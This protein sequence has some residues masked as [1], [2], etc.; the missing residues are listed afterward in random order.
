[1]RDDWLESLRKESNEES[2]H[3][4]WQE[5]RQYLHFLASRSLDRSLASK[6]DASDIAQHSLLEM[7]NDFH[8]FKG[9]TKEELKAWLERLV[10]HNVRDSSRKYIQSEKRN[11]RREKVFS[12]S[13]RD[14][15]PAQ[16]PSAS[17]VYIK[18]ESDINLA[19]AL[20]RLPTSIRQLVE[21][22]FRRG[23]SVSQI[24]LL[25]NISEY[26]VRSQVDQAITL[27]RRELTDLE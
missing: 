26:K 21:L 25:M 9:T 1:M 7:Q 12:D 6:V 16:S 20:N 22:R 10:L 2:L 23:L 8:R 15:L 14:P 5:I 17:E 27:L 11:V 19:I 18:Q 24:A 13:D 3:R 4:L